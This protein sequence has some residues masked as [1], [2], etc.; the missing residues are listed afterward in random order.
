MKVSIQERIQL[1]KLGYSREDIEA[2]INEPDPE[3][4]TE[5]VTAPLPDVP[6]AV[7]GTTDSAVL[8][9]LQ[10]IKTQLQSMAVMNSSAPVL[11]T[12]QSTFD[13]LNNIFN[14]KGVN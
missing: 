14:N 2:M 1:H 12:T 5:T 9:A 7:Q 3:P 6:K 13:I 4:A 11:D 8:S 10:D